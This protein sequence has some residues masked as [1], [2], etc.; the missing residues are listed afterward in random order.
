MKILKNIITFAFIVGAFIYSGYSFYLYSLNPCDRPLEYAIGRFDTE[1]GVSQEKFK[2][3]ITEAGSVW[4]K[5]LNKKMFLYNPKAKFKINLIYDVRQLATAQKQKTEFGLSAAEDILKQLDS[6]FNQMKAAYDRRL[7]AHQVAGSTFE[8]EQKSYE[9]KV[10]YWNVQN[11]APSKA[12]Y[13]LLQAEGRSL[14]VEAKQL[15]DEGRLLNQ[16]VK[17]LNALLDKRNEAA[18]AYNQVAQNYN[19]KYGHGLEFNQAEY[20]GQAI[21]VYQFGSQKDLAVA[22]AHELGHA[23][24]LNHTENPA[25]IMYYMTG[26]NTAVKPSPSTEDLAELRR[27]CK[28]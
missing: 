18:R 17:E 21:N 22:L 7:M 6:E 26:G 9:S 16:S 14:N 2:Y 25:S 1:F 8:V 19:Q 12:E 3:Q 28:M 11:G 27:V 24:G 23:L 13:E 20:T 5:A 15:N 4:E 10:N